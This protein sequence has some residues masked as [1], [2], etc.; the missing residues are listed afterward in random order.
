MLELHG[1][2]MGDVVVGVQGYRVESY[3]HYDFLVGMKP[4]S[5]FEL[6]VWDGERYRKVE[7]RA[8]GRKF[9]IDMATFR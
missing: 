6:I 3:E 7:A 8:P 9:G 2:K 5:T 4:G 1:L